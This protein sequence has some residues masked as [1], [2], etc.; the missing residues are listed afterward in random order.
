MKTFVL[1]LPPKPPTDCAKR[2]G[3]TVANHKPFTY[4][5]SHK[6]MECSQL[7]VKT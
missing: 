7:Y 1:I 6:S 5:L 3:L 2:V 4:I